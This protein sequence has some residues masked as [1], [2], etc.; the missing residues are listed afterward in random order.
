[1][2]KLNI[3]L[4]FLFTAMGAMAQNIVW[5]DES[6][7]D[8]LSYASGVNVA[9]GMNHQFEYVPFDY[10]ILDKT[11]SNT[12]LG[13]ATLEEDS[14]TITKEELPR[15]LNE[16]FGEKYPDRMK[17]AKAESDSLKVSDK[18]AFL[19]SKIFETQYERAY[20]TKA[21]AMN[22]G[23]GIN[24]SPM[25]IQVYWVLRGMHDFRDGKAVMNNEK[26]MNYINHYMNVTRVE[27]IKKK[28]NAWLS[29]VV[30]QKGV[31]ALPSGLIY[32]IEV[33]GDKNVMPVDDTDVVTVHYKGV[34]QSGE[35]FD[36][37]RFADKPEK[38]QQKL[39]M[40]R[41]NDYN[42]DEPISFALNQVIAGW[43]EGIKLIGKG[44]KITLW[45]PYNLAYGERGAGEA[46]APYEALR[47]DIELIDVKKGSAK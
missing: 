31:K 27:E 40:Y 36:A 2:K 7:L 41:P 44:G 15:I 3:L 26:A 46:I 4:V 35:S 43:T 38:V 30:Q 11:V 25:P 14:L 28:S 32:K 42:K 8:S 18:K 17:V 24:Q 23:L 19:M 39:K 34:K 47:F 37:T 13:V 9:Y 21:F 1:M 22:L 29:S 12:A 6:K 16:F 5:G 20:V 33:E 10:D 45:I